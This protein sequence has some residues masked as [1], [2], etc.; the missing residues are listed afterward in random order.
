[1]N[2]NQDSQILFDRRQAG[3]DFC[4]RTDPSRCPTDDE[5]AN[6]T[7][8]S[9]VRHAAVYPGTAADGPTKAGLAYQLRVEQIL[10]ALDQANQ[11][12]ATIN[13]HEL[14][15]RIGIG[16]VESSVTHFLMPILESFHYRYPRVTL[17]M[18]DADGDDIKNRLDRGLLELGIVST[19]INAAKYH[20]CHLPIDDQWGLAVQPTS[21]L[22]HQTTVG[23][24]ELKE[25]PLIV[26]GRSLILEEVSD[27]L[28]NNQQEL[29][30]VATY[31]LLANGAFLAA[32]GLG[33]LL[34]IKGAPFPAGLD[35]H[36]IP[37]MPPRTLEHYL[38]WRKGS[39]VSKPA[40]R[41]IKLLQAKVKASKANA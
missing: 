25:E 19:P 29:R 3:H 24:D 23:I 11:V 14:T 35:L 4:R 5:P 34:C 8:G 17:E 6:S 1:M 28:K 13:N 40:D 2:G 36:F 16:C 15:G 26:P 30:I 39:A 21:H 9:A 37:L 10:A 41:L 31:N 27:W 33:S 32:A 12:V 18:Y 7:V 38:I 22:S 20:Y